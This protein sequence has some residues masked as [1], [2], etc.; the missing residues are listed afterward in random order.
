MLLSHHHHEL[1]PRTTTGISRSRSWYPSIPS[2]RLKFRVEDAILSLSTSNLMQSP[3]VYHTGILRAFFD[4]YSLRW[5]ASQ[6]TVQLLTHHL[7]LIRISPLAGS[8]N[9][10]LTAGSIFSTLFMVLSPIMTFSS[11]LST[12]KLLS[13]PAKRKRTA[14]H[15]TLNLPRST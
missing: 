14:N 4:I 13:E 12:K 15:T 1:P 7:G 5:S 6:P 2:S 11:R 8:P 3:S 9:L 10:I